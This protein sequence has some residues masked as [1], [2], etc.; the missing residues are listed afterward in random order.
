MRN[1]NSNEIDDNDFKNY[2]SLLQVCSYQNRIG[3]LDNKNIYNNKSI[4]P[5]SDFVIVNKDCYYSFNSQKNLSQE[6]IE[7]FSL[8]FFKGN[9]LLKL[10]PKQFLLTFKIIIKDKDGKDN[11]IHRDLILTIIEGLEEKNI[12]NHLTYLPDLSEWLKKSD[13]DYNSTETIQA[14]ITAENKNGIVKLDNKTLLINKGKQ[15]SNLFNTIKPQSDNENNQT[16]K[17]INQYSEKQKTEIK[18][19]LTQIQNNTR[20]LPFVNK[21]VFN[22]DTT[23]NVGLFIQNSKMNQMNQINQINQINHINQ[24]NQMN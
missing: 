11:E 5:L 23:L 3:P 21:E 24:M 22:G 16:M 8:V 2:F 15:F 6:K 19:Q 9:Y 7:S 4:N 18:R 17:E 13:F 10:N 20:N 14:T 12:I 1:N